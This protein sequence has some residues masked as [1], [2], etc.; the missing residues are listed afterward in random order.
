MGLG[1]LQFETRSGKRNQLAYSLQSFSDKAVICGLDFEAIEWYSSSTR[2]IYRW[3]IPPPLFYRVE[4]DCRM[5]LNVHIYSPLWPHLSTFPPPPY[6]SKKVT[7]GNVINGLVH[8]FPTSPPVEN[9]ALF[10]AVWPHLFS[11]RGSGWEINSR[12][13]AGV[14]DSCWP[15]SWSV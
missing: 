1:R 7:P 10:R 9:K 4:F 15:V 8:L 2:D 14:H 6:G 12:L 13:C 5:N 3:R 11:R